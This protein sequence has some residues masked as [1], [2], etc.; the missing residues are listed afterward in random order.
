LDVSL[1]GRAD[2]EV[3][4]V[5][6]ADEPGRAKG[7]AR[8][9]AKRGYAD[10]REMIEKERPQLVVVGPRITPERREM[11]L[12]A[13]GAGAHVFSEKP[14]VRSPADADEVLA[15]A[16]SKGLRIAVAHQMRLAPAVVHL[17]KK[18][19]AGLIGDIAEMRAVG[20]QDKRAG[21]EDLAVLG[22]HLFDLMRLF[23]G[24]DA[25]SCQA[26][27][28]EK[29]RPATLADVRA[30]TED[31]GPV[32]GDE[33]FARFAFAG[34]LTGSFT[35]SARL[36]D[37]SGYWGLELVGTKGSARILA[38]IWPRVMYRAFGKWSDAGRDDAWRP[39]DD[40]AAANATPA[41]RTNGPA[42]VRVAEDW[43][44]ALRE[45]REPACSGQKAAK[46]IEMQTAVWRAGLSG[47][48]VALPL[49]DRGHPLIK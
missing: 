11:L 14:F 37:E 24:A 47:A 7:V 33:I 26:T 20:K 18:I 32:L 5:A 16:A 15:L 41:E 29:G 9:K 40:D 31:I 25:V 49:K 22:I 30:A 38:D 3:V 45:K 1:A 8:C 28:L 48:S 44:A 36:R 17:K 4:A 21:G 13:L 6:D 27:V 39:L 10:Y 43:L 42:N 2:V 12:A 34:G 35:S 46:A 23:A 19:D